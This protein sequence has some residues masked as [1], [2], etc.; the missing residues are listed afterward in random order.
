MIT[1]YYNLN[2]LKSRDA[3]ALLQQ[4]GPD[5]VDVVECLK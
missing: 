5:N 2:G 4:Y 1:I 3:L